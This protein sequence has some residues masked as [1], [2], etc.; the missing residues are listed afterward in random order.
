[1]SSKHLEEHIND[2]SFTQSRIRNICLYLLSPAQS[3]GILRDQYM[4]YLEDDNFSEVLISIVTKHI[5]MQGI[6]I[7]F[8][9][10]TDEGQESHT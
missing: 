3:G 8:Q 7:I 1:M 9:L 2:V 5:P 6:G 4:W 10:V